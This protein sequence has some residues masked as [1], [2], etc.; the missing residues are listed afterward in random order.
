MKRVANNVA[1]QTLLYVVG[2]NQKIR[3]EDRETNQQTGRTHKVVFEGHEKDWCFLD[4]RDR[5]LHA[6]VHA[7]ETDGDTLVF[8]IDTSN[9]TY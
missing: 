5:E 4:R 7:I 9:E 8:R 1:L 2:G 6:T 3:I